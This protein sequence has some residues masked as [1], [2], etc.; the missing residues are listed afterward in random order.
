[1]S[2][3]TGKM[4]KAR[5]AAW[6]NLQ[7]YLPCSELNTEA[8]TDVTGELAIAAVDD[9]RTTEH[10]VDM[11]QALGAPSVGSVVA[12]INSTKGFILLMQSQVNSNDGFNQFAIGTSAA[13]DWIKVS[14]ASGSC[15]FGAGSEEIATM[16]GDAVG[17]GNNVLTAIVYN[18]ADSSLRLYQDIN[19]AGI[20]LKD[21]ESLSAAQTPDFSLTNNLTIH[22]SGF[23]QP[24]YDVAFLIFDTVPATLVDDLDDVRR[25]WIQGRPYLPESWENA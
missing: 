15:N 16:L 20:S 9:A 17:N 2:L 1:M 7:F 22:T 5:Y 24:T 3:L 14:A 6:D 13:N 19:G 10:A 21:T 12:N 25:N 23:E 18:P 4:L 8:A 11:F